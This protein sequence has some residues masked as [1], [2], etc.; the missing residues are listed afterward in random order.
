[1]F[2]LL[3]GKVPTL[4]RNKFFCKGDVSLFSINLIIFFSSVWTRGHLFYIL[5]YRIQS[6]LIYFVVHVILALAFGTS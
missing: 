1:M 3:E 6:Y 2:H 5:G 4:I